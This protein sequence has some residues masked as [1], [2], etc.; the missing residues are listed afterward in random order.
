L[1][2]HTAGPFQGKVLSPNGIIAACVENGVGYIDVCD[3]YCTATAAKTKYSAKAI[4]NKVPCILSTGCWPGVSSLM[5]K[6]LTRSVLKKRPELSAEDLT[7]DF[8]FFTSGSG[9][10]GATLLVA[11]FLILAEKSLTIVNGRRRE[12]EA[13]KDYSR[14]NFGGIVG[15]KD[16]AHLNLLEAA[17]VHE[18]LGIGNVKTLFGTAPGFWNVLLGAMAQLPSSLL[19]NEPIMEKLALF[20]LPIVRI[21]DFFAGA[22]N[23]MRVDVSS[24]KDPSVQEMALYAHENLEPCVGECVTAFCAALLGDR[25]TPGVWFPEEAIVTEEDVSSVLGLSSV[26]AHT[27]EVKSSDG[28]QFEDVWGSGSEKR[29]LQ[30][31]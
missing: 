10:A 9:G 14:V 31:A 18:V 8:S 5:A 26:G 28:L 11:T 3:D 16:V 7:V 12:V 21:V 19:S 29:V 13:M 24:N 27:L 4:E 2:V 30:Q 15:D 23:A 17:S 25:V 20:S 22:T 1:V 6:Q